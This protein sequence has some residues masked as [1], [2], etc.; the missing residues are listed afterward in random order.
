MEQVR[1]GIIGCGYWGPKLIR[2]F[3]ELPETEVV[4]VADLDRAK[5]A[6]IR[7]AF[8]AVE[9]TTDHEELLASTVDAVA[10]ATPVSTHYRLA[11]EA[12]LRGKH[13]LVE[14]PITACSRD[15]QDLIE[16]ARDRDLRL[17]VGH[18]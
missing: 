12:L 6:R 5:L 15:A 8:P 1:I 10:I 4:M 13:V 14:K 18:V 16:L 9:V 3:H 7:S 17:M 11:R 2:N